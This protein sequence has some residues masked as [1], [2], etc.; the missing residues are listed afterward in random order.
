MGDETKKPGEGQDGSDGVSYSRVLH[1]ESRTQGD[2]PERDALL[3]LMRERAADPAVFDRFPASL[4][5]GQISASVWDAYDTRMA[6]S[7][8][9]NYAAEAA[10][11]TAFMRGHRTRGEDPIGQSLTGV[12]TGGQGN[13]V[14]RVASD[15]F[16]ISD[17]DSEVFVNRMLAGVI[18]D[19][20]VGFYGGEWIC[21]ICGRDMEQWMSRDGCRHMLGFMY[22]PRDE[23]GTAT[24]DPVKARATIENAHLSEFSGVF[25]GATPGCMIAKARGMAAEGILRGAERELVEVRFKLALPAYAKRIAVNESTTEERTMAEKTDAEIAQERFRAMMVRCGAPSDKSPDEQ[26][27]WLSDELKRL[28]DVEAEQP[29]L[30]AL[31]D[32]G[33]QYRADLLAEGLKQGARA[34]G[35]DFKEET[36]RGMLEKADIETIKRMTADWQKVGDDVFKGGRQTV[37]ESTPEDKTGGKGEKRKVSFAAF[38]V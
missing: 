19:L 4:F 27:R 1:I 29:K 11:G 37:D 17:P 23:A 28:R 7:S 6:Q 16:V 15:W 5:K 20:S 14:A 10:L 12:F 22:T 18:R 31:A 13:G 36:Y 32:E 25:D 9:K 26:E 21:S 30:R 24:G 2:T 8:L 38:K 33:K 3:K 35:K 34:L